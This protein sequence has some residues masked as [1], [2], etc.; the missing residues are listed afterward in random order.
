SL[1]TVDEAFVREY[2]PTTGRLIDLGCGTGRL[3]VSL[4]ARGDRV[5]GVDLSPEMLAVARD[6]ARAGGVEVDLLRANLVHLEGLAD[7]CF[8]SG[9]CLSSTLGMVVG[10]ANRRR[11]VEHPSR[12][13]RPG[14]RFILHVHTRWFDAW[15][16]AGRAWLW[17]D[18]LGWNEGERGDRVM[19]P[20]Q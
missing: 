16:P 17:R 19:P 6:K 2:C 1:F 9:A 8:D 20:H 5:L 3:L 7:G 10:S 4:A 14:G 12:L 15:N 11:V 13:L 18:L